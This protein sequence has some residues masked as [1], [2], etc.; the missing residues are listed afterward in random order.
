MKKAVAYFVLTAFLVA[1]FM[2]FATSNANAQIPKPGT[3]TG[4]EKK[5][6][7]AATPSVKEM[8]VKK[9]QTFTI[10]L[11]INAANGMKW[12]IN[13]DSN[14]MI[15]THVSDKVVPIMVKKNPEAKAAPAPKATGKPEPKAT[16]KPEVKATGT[17]APK[18]SPAAKATPAAKPVLVKQGDEQ[19]FTF[20]AK[21]TGNTS[22]E[23]ILARP[24][25]TTAKEQ[26]NYDITV[27]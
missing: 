22:V 24:E 14:P 6:S 3:T 25:Q 11:P 19:V 26:R 12:R 20:K 23:F 13:K 4:A 8:S 1:A 9:G 15:L 7:T 5:G 27:E 16:G 10:K 17:P 18:A 2:V 21:E